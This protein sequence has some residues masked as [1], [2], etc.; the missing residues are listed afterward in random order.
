MHQYSSSAEKVVGVQ[1]VHRVAVAT[2]TIVRTASTVAII[3]IIA[4]AINP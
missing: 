3:A 1:M 2:V 4:V